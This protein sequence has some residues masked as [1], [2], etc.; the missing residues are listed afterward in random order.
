[1]LKGGNLSCQR[2]ECGTR[3]SG[4]KMGNGKW[5]RCCADGFVVVA[6]SS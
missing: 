3:W 6:L 1:V 5:K 4:R 2:S